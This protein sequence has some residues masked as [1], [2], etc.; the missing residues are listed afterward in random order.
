MATGNASTTAATT[1]PKLLRLPSGA[2][3]APGYYD[4]AKSGIPYIVKEGPNGTAVV[5]SQRAGLI[6]I[7]KEMNSN[8]LAG[9]FIRSKIA[10][11]VPEGL[12]TA[13]NNFAPA[14]EG[15]QTAATNAIEAATP[16]IDNIKAGAGNIVGGLFGG[17][18]GG[19]KLQNPAAVVAPNLPT[20]QPGMR[21]RNP[22]GGMYAPKPVVAPTVAPSAPANQN[23][24]IGQTYR[25]T[26]GNLV[27]ATPGGFRPV[28]SNF[29][30]SGRTRASVGET[31]DSVWAEAKGWI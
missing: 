31:A 4:N 30:P 29:A 22:A 13:A 1:A 18:F 12:A 28:Q 2:M 10:E 20:D 25:T 15:V 24:Q 5:E 6:D 21:G 19:P 27:V 23:I 8:T 7:G 11:M 16:V 9:G 3:I 14:V 26:N 17:L